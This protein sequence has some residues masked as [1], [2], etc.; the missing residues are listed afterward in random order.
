MANATKTALFL[1]A[2]VTGAVALSTP[3][4]AQGRE[5]CYGI[6]KAGE[7][8]CGN[9]APNLGIAATHG[10]AGQA[11]VDYSGLEWKAVAAGTCETELGGK[12]EP[13]EGVNDA[14]VGG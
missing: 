9:G 3:A 7:N 1:A 11:T 6:A 8:H 13:F 12:L 2:A 10:C 14:K 4:D 5:K